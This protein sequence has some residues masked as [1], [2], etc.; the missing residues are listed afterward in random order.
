MGR[1]H[2]I[3]FP[4]FAMRPSSFKVARTQ[5]PLKNGQFSQSFALFETFL[6]DPALK[7]NLMIFIY[8]GQNYDKI[9]CRRQCKVPPRHQNGG[10][11]VESHKQKKAGLLL[12]GTG[13]CVHSAQSDRQTTIPAMRSQWLIWLVHTMVTIILVF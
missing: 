3:R 13:R 6:N 8:L 9:L 11:S 5:K 12:V 10:Q 4:S 1:T 2:K 7:S